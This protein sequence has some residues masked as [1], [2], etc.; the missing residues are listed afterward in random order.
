MRYSKGCVDLAARSQVE[1]GVKTTK[2]DQG[3]SFEIPARG[4]TIYNN[5]L[6]S[7]CLR[8]VARGFVCS[9]HKWLM[10]DDWPGTMKFA[11]PFANGDIVFV[12][13]EARTGVPG[14][15]LD[16]DYPKEAQLECF[17]SGN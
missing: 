10:F 15:G 3:G 2:S 13:T 7:N 6:L 4:W 5:Y 12:S 14:F 1:L 16:T 8:V 9:N 17:S 11:K